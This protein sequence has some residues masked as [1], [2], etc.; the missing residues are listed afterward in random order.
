MDE[1]TTGRQRQILKLVLSRQAMARPFVAPPGIPDERK[2]ALR[3]AFA[4]TLRDPEF[5][6]DADRQRLEI[7]AVSGA[8]IDKLV[9]E[10]YQ[11]PKD[12]I[13]ETRAAIAAAH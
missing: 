6:A 2:A 3:A 8:D 12:V 1:A 5:R 11:T 4:A 9:A 13:A 7:G 10:L